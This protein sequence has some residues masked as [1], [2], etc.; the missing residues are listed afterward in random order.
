MHPLVKYPFQISKK[1]WSI[2][3][4]KSIHNIWYFLFIKWPL[5]IIFT[6]CCRFPFPWFLFQGDIMYCL[7]HVYSIIVLLCRYRN[8]IFGSSE[9]FFL[10]NF[11]SFYVYI[12]LI[13]KITLSSFLFLKVIYIN[14]ISHI[15]FLFWPRV[16]HSKI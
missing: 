10:S 11:S 13:F 3:I 14:S 5:D 12:H 2:C 15:D 4:L 16:Y 1:L 9:T 6:G 8:N 7:F